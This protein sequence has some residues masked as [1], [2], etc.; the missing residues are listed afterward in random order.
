MPRRVP[1]PR[2]DVVYKHDGELSDD[3]SDED[4][5]VHARR[6]K[7]RLLRQGIREGARVEGGGLESCG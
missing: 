1:Q 3:S 2:N 4:L 5:D 6:H 7:G